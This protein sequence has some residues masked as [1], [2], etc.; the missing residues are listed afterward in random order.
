VERRFGL[1]I[2]PGLNVAAEL[3][4]KHDL[5]H[6]DQY[7]WEDEREP[8]VMKLTLTPTQVANMW[9]PNLVDGSD[10][11]PNRV[12]ARD[13][14]APSAAGAWVLEGSGVRLVKLAVLFKKLGDRFSAADICD[15][16][17]GLA[18][19][20]RKRPRRA[21]TPWTASSRS[22]PVRSQV[23]ARDDVVAMSRNA[24]RSLLLEHGVDIGNKTEEISRVAFRL[25][26][27][28]LERSASWLRDPTF[29]GPS[30]AGPIPYAYAEF[31]AKTALPKFV[32]DRMPGLNQEDGLACARVMLFCPRIKRVVEDG[33]EKDMVCG[34]LAADVTNKFQLHIG[35]REVSGLYCAKCAERLPAGESPPLSCRLLL[36][37]WA[38]MVHG[39]ALQLFLEGVGDETLPESR[40][41]GRLSERELIVPAAPSAAGKAGGKSA[42][43]IGR[44][45]G[46]TE[47]AVTR[48]KA[49]GDKAKG[50]WTAVTRQA[51]L[52]SAA[53]WGLVG[54]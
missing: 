1:K 14:R 31:V 25:R 45:A 4:A 51:E 7:A 24:A 39:R 37:W 10:G 17:V 50:I 53:L 43:K 35:G 52:S 8:P 44:K 15:F 54:M 33:Q 46:G 20:A 30:A 11:Q 21:E 13:I 19:Y 47:R 27:V 34:R 48:I 12:L 18:V 6:M 32:L 26:A 40:C 42:G 29:V 23:H 2:A 9:K 41:Q 16:F 3:A 28:M 5:F 38:G 36:L 49:T 22:A